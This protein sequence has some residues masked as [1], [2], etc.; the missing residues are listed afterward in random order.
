MPDQPKSSVPVNRG[1]DE[2]KD[3]YRLA[4][5]RL[6]IELSLIA[7]EQT[8]QE[9]HLLAASRLN[10]ELS[11]IGSQQTFCGQRASSNA[12]RPVRIEASSRPPGA[13]HRG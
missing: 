13:R 1:I 2:R 8:L 5:S 11:L 9:T 10:I 7:S 4:A 12:S 3:R 6:N